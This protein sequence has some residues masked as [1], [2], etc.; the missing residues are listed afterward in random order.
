MN[1]KEAIERIRDHNRIH[2]KTEPYTPLLNEAMCMA[3]DALE[4][5][6]PLKL[7]YKTGFTHC[8]CGYE[9]EDEG[10]SNEE[11]CPKCGQKVWVGGYNGEINNVVNFNIN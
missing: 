1:E 2:S 7:E 8:K 4:K 6:I 3:I 5:Q 9:F 10:Y 11:Y